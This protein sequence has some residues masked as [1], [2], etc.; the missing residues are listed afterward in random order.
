MEQFVARVFQGGKVTVPKRLRELLGVE[1]GVYVRM[2]V[3]E[4]VKPKARHKAK[5]SLDT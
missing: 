4:V 1:D 3:L 5:H 2:A